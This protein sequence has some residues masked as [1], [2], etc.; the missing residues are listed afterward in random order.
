MNKSTDFVGQPI[1]FQLLTLI[2][3]PI[4]KETILEQKAKRAVRK[5]F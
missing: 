1:F 2:G 4:I 3:K 5:I